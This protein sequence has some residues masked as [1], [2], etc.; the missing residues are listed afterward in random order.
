MPDLYS[1]PQNAFLH[2]REL[3]AVSVLHSRQ[4][5]ETCPTGA[6][7][8]TSTPIRLTQTCVKAE[9]LDTPAA[10][11]LSPGRL[12]DSLSPSRV[13][14]DTVLPQSSETI[15]SCVC[16]FPLC[17]FSFVKAQ[18]WDLCRKGRPVLKCKYTLS[19]FLSKWDHNHVKE[20]FYCGVFEK[21]NVNSAQITTCM[22]HNLLNFLNFYQKKFCCKC[23]WNPG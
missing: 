5:E 2:Q 23:R 13:Q 1:N 8:Q 14:T 12:V 21:I 11:C 17:H 7:V 16:F 10:A 3:S 6:H 22:R 20:L 15:M 19:L 4:N 9:Q 18:V